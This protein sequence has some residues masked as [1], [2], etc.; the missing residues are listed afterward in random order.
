[1]SL[2]CFL[3]CMILARALINTPS[4]SWFVLR[5]GDGAVSAWNTFVKSIIPHAH[6]GEDEVTMW[7]TT[8]IRV[9]AETHPYWAVALLSHFSKRLSKALGNDNVRSF[10]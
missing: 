10:C 3:E 7:A 4:L 5:Q 2:L 9:I 8:A 6:T 1:M